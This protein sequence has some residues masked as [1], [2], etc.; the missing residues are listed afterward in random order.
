MNKIVLSAIAALTLGTT[1]ASA[2]E[3]YQDANGQVFTSKGEGRTLVEDKL[4]FSAQAFIGYKATDYKDSTKSGTQDFEIHR[5]WL[6][7]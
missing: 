4:K 1:T 6:Q 3:W 5:G 2:V 7:V